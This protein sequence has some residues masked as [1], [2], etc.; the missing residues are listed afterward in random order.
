MADGSTGASSNV[1][2]LK[3]REEDEAL[4]DIDVLL[5]KSRPRHIVDGLASG[6]G[7]IVAGAL[8]ACGILVLS[9]QVGASAGYERGGGTGDGG[10]ADEGGGGGSILGG[11]V[12]GLVGGVVGVGSA[13]SVATGGVLTGTG[14]IFRGI[15]NTPAS[16]IEPRRGKW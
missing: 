7:Y 12:G 13:L 15:V 8:G 11:L 2:N 5:N 14:Q 3:R 16:V 10:N 6:F 1:P 9:P 4:N